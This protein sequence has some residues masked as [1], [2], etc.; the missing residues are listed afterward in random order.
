MCHVQVVESHS[1]NSGRR[2]YSLRIQYVQLTDICTKTLGTFLCSTKSKAKNKSWTMFRSLEGRKALHSVKSDRKFSG[3]LERDDQK[4]H[5]SFQIS[6]N[7]ES[8]E[9]EWGI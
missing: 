8:S 4:Y 2:V 6:L 5:S 3:S 9:P 1:V 7:P